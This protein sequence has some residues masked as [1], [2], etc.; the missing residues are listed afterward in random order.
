AFRKAHQ[1]LPTHRR[2]HD[3]LRLTERWLELDKQLPDIL[4][5]KAKPNSPQEQLELALFCAQCKEHYHAAVGFFSD[6]FTA[7]PK[8]ANTVPAEARYDAARAAA[9]A[10]A[11]KG[12]DAGTLDD[13]ERGRLR[14]QA[15]DWLRADFAAYTRLAEKGNPNLRR[16]IQQRLAHWQ[17]DTDLA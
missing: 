13:K 4:T 12:V 11:G 8:L 15:L 7:A 1:L 3:D 10:A 9:L 5:G 17:E 14:Q 2:I 16:A 6:A